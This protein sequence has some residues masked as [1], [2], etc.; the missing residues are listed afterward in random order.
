MFPEA[1]R[2]KIHMDQKSDSLRKVVPCEILYEAQ[3]IFPS[4]FQ[5]CSTIAHQTIDR[6]QGGSYT[7]VSA[8]IKQYHVSSVSYFTCGLYF[9]RRA[10]I[11]ICNTDKNQQYSPLTFSFLLWCA[12]HAQ[13]TEETVQDFITQPNKTTS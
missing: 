8:K 11:Y 2:Q 9:K 6:V 12:A 7:K 4:Q 1:S 13:P 5:G 3:I 10:V